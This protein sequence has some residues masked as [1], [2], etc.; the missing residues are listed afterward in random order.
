MPLRERPGGFGE[1]DDAA[2]TVPGEGL[3]IDAGILA[4]LIGDGIGLRR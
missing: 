3:A 2:A 4:Q 1:R